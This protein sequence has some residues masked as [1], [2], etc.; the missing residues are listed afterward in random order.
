MSDSTFPNAQNNAAAA[1]PVWLAGSP[2]GGGA[3]LVSLSGTKGASSGNIIP[4]ATYARG[5]TL[6]NTST[7]GQTLYVSANATATTADF[8]IAA[9]GSLT[10]AFGVAN[11]LQA[12]GSAAGTTWAAVGA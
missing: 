9:G 12:I 8:A 4:A 7:G 5:F 11:A 1:I 6:Q 3:T 10:V 2:G